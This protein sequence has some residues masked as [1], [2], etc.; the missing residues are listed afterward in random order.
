MVVSFGHD[1]MTKL[2]GRPRHA[3]WM[4]LFVC[5]FPMVSALGSRSAF[6]I[7]RR[8]KEAAP[9]VPATTTRT[10]ERSRS[11]LR[12]TI[13]FKG[14]SSTSISVRP[15]SNLGTERNSSNDKTSNSLPDW[16]LSPESDEFFLGTQDF[17][18]RPDGNWDA[19]QASVEWFGLQLVPV[20]VIKLERSKPQQYVSA[21]IQQARSDIKSGKDSALGRLAAPVMEKSSFQGGNKVSW[22][23][24]KASEGWILEADLSLTVSIP[25]PLFLPLPPGFNT[26]GSRIVKSTCKRRLETF[27]NDLQASYLDWAEKE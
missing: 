4:L 1:T 19:F 16:M 24:N 26:I 13:S 23:K 15:P 7:V 21:I 18:R 5:C 25:L 20:F 8:R 9:P 3:V 22:K 17:K 27:V 11:R 10:S 6:A 2:N 14:E 12:A